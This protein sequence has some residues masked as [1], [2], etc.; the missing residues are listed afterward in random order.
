MAELTKADLL[1]AKF[2]IEAVAVPELGENATIHLREMTAAG[3]VAY[4]ALY[5][6]L[7]E[8]RQRT[9][10]LMDF[11]LARSICNAEGQRLFGDDDSPLEAMTFAVAN[12]LWLKALEINRIEDADAKKDSETATTSTSRA[13]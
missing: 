12:R 6:S 1:S 13:A 3:V 4:A 7:E 10:R 2:K 9:P 8:E 5:A 11:M